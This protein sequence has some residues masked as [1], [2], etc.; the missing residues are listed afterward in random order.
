M[1]VR[2]AKCLFCLLLPIFLLSCS[3]KPQNPIAVYGDSMIEAQRKTRNTAV[4]ANLDA[5]QKSVQ[6]YHAANDRYPESLKDIEGMLDR[7]VDLNLYAYDS[8]TGIVHIK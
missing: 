2:I 6:A 7:S 5:L 8:A 4:T 1:A 3:D